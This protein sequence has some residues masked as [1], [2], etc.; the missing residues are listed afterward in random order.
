MNNPIK[1]SVSSILLAGI[2]TGCSQQQIQQGYTDNST[3]VDVQA[4]K[5]Q[6]VHK[7][8]S[9]SKKV[10]VTKKKKKKSAR[11]SKKKTKKI[12]KKSKKDIGLPPAKAGQCYAKVKKAAKYK[13]LSKRILIK[14]ASSKRVVSRAPQYQ[15]VNK[16][17]LVK[18]AGYTQRIIP[19]VYKTI[20]K[21]VMVKPSYLTWKKGKGLITKID[22]TTGE[23]LCR[24]KVPATYKKVKQKVLVQAART[25]KTP[26]AAVYK[27]VKHKK[28]ISPTQYK[29]IYTPAR[30]KTKKYRVKTAASK[31]VWRQVICETNVSKSQRGRA[32]KK[33]IHKVKR[34]KEKSYVKKYPKPQRKTR[35][36][37]KNRHYL[38]QKRTNL[39]KATFSRK[40]ASQQRV[41]KTASRLNKID[42]V[43][44]KVVIKA[45]PVPV[46]RQASKKSKPKVR[47][48]KANAVFRIQ[49][50]LAEKGFSPGK[51]DGKLGPATVAALTAF[52]RKNGLPTGRL[53]RTT[54]Q[55]LDLI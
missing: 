42:N 15:W 5:Q 47:L 12:R 13:T 17:V 16:R 3:P 44:P 55:A 53:N 30:Y 54:L 22:N 37:S 52:Q 21:K 50:A 20:T 39:R 6:P 45:E 49:T 35:T 11:K 4:S 14:K 34:Y 10:K 28:L 36:Q 46:I 33:K 48:T 51:I 23:I 32:N 24:V 38:A 41:R 25:I 26:Q 8:I 18:P 19:A 29:T 7:S 31:Y 2:M 40:V 43:A 1:L 27:T 9:R